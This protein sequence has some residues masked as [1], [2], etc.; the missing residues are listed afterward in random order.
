M[1][2]PLRRASP[3]STLTAPSL[4]LC[5]P[6]VSSSCS[7]CSSSCLLFM[8][9]LLSLR[10]P[11]TRLVILCPLLQRFAHP[12]PGTHTVRSPIPAGTMPTTRVTGTTSFRPRPPLRS[13]PLCVPYRSRPLRPGTRIPQQLPSPIYFPQHLHPRHILT[14]RTLY[15]H[16]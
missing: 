16:F 5:L 11:L 12:A 4:I 10:I 3:C 14:H 6:S 7:S 8:S 2:P 9:L 13:L 1:Q 15:L